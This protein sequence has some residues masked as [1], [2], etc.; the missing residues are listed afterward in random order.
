MMNNLIIIIGIV[1]FFLIEKSVENFLGV[2]HD[3][4]HDGHSHSHSHKHTEE[5]KDKGSK[6]ELSN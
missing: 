3:H 5:S 2:G 6:K 1:S 4:S